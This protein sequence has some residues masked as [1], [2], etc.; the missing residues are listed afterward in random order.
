MED[1]TYIRV[2]NGKRVFNPST[3]QYA[4]YTNGGITVGS[5]FWGTSEGSS[6][7][8]GQKYDR[9]VLNVTNPTDGSSFWPII[10]WVSSS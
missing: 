1:S 6:W 4:F 5:H 3:E 9:A 8:D 7:L 10:R 2:Y